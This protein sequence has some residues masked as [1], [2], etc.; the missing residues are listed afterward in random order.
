[1]FRR[2]I[3]G[4]FFVYLYGCAPVSFTKD[5]ASVVDPCANN[6]CVKETYLVEQDIVPSGGKMDIIIVSDNSASMSFEQAKMGSRMI[7]F[8]DVLVMKSV[9]YRIGVITTDVETATNKPRAINGNGALQ[10]G[11]LI[12][13]TNGAYYITP[14]T[15][16]LDSQKDLLAKAVQRKETDQCETLIKT[17]AANSVN[18]NT[19]E[20]RNAYYENCPTPDER[21]IYAAA[22]S[23]KNNSSFFRSDAGLAYVIISDEDELSYGHIKTSTPSVWDA[24]ALEDW[25]MP[26]KLVSYAKSIKGSQPFEVS[27]IVVKPGDNV[28]LETQRD[29][30]FGEGNG[31][32]GKVLMSLVTQTSGIPGS[33][34]AND[35][36]SQLED[37]G[38]SIGDKIKN[39][40]LKCSNPTDFVLKIVSGTSTRPTYTIN[41]STLIFD[42]VLPVGIKL[43]AVYTC[44]K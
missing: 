16:S 43:K 33:V 19:T 14:S 7:S 29:Q 26:E 5:K 40:E 10:N 42:Q 9:D 28:C 18:R 12:Q 23:L 11:K 13:F 21:P 15:G 6:A 38:R 41:G 25:D 44:T 35:Y 2:T 31:Q 3:A 36:G 20:A 37:M 17:Q 39:V 24:Y 1:M 32:F 34:C 22:L 30:L 4:L 8:L 27:A